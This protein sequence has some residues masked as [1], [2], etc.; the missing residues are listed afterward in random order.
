MKHTTLFFFLSL[1]LCLAVG[2]SKDDPVSDVRYDL[3]V[4]NR[5]GMDL[6]V[7]LKST[8][9]TNY[10][11]QGTVLDSTD[12]VIIDLILDIAYTVGVIEV[13]GDPSTIVNEIPVT[14]TDPTV[15]NYILTIN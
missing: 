10:V 14:N 6:D 7:Y 8:L 11:A 2:C 1:A 9:N 4:K 5:S 15:S 12:K 3:T 13:G